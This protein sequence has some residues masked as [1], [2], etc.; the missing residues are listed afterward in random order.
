MR[1]SPEGGKPESL[2]TVGTGELA[3]GPQILPGGDAV[4]FTLARGVAPDRWD[5]AQIV[6]QSLKSGKR[7]LL[8]EGGSDGRY[9]PTGHI[10]YAYGGTLFAVPFDLKRLS[11]T[12]G[13]VPVVEG[14]RRSTSTTGTAQFSFSNNGSLIYVP[15]P[16]TAGVQLG[17][18]LVDR[19]GSVESLELPQAAFAAPRI[20]PEGTRVAFGMDDG[21]EAAIWIYELSG[22]TSMR[23]LT[24]GGAN[25]YPVWTHDGKRIAFQSDR[26]GDLGIFWQQ[27]DGLGTAER[28]TKAEQGVAHIPDS[29]SPNDKRLSFTAVKGNTTAIH[30]FSLEDR[31]DSVFAEAPA[32]STYMALSA[33]AFSPDGKWVAYHSFETGRPSVWAQPFPGTGIKQ[34]VS[35]DSFLPF[36][37]P[38]GRELLFNSR[39]MGLVA[40]AVT[41]QPGFSFGIP[42]P[43]PARF[44]TASAQTGSAVPRN[45]DITPDG[46]RFIAVVALDQTGTQATQ[47]IQVV[48]NW[49][50][51]LQQRVPVK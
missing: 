33:S 3:H 39:T 36:W 23:R 5:K 44:F 1:V 18:S 15:G 31:K 2:V 47:Q 22:R 4:L 12:G 41:T 46:K 30:V 9:L 6:V 50:S 20:S 29:W 48:L 40:V 10:V 24:V 45:I 16:A 35:T 42:T 26:E 17:L 38:D 34:Q 28:L 25:R 19:K 13:A 27:A 37:S 49:F 14:V 11:I 43:L 7:N 32:S 8:F 21:K 51:E